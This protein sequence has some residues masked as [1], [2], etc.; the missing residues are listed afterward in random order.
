MKMQVCVFPKLEE[1]HLSK[2]NRLTDIWQ[3]EVSVDSFSNI[4]SVKIE[5]CYKLNKIFPS[6]MKGW[7]ECLDNLTVCSCESV[8]VIFEINDYEKID[9]FGGINTN[10]QVILLENLPKLKQLWSTDPGGIL[11][12]KKLR[13][14]DVCDCDE[15]INLFPASVAEDVPKLE[16]ISTLYCEKMVEIVTSQ[17]A[18]YANNDPL[19]FPELTCVRLEWLPN[20]KRFCKG[21]HLIKCPKLKQF[22]IHKRVKLNTF[23]KEIN[24]TTNKEEKCVF[25]AEEVTNITTF[26]DVRF[27]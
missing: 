24:E 18:S 1:I 25:S 7:V 9:E 4:I 15:L 26:F 14:M 12:F 6:H 27:L 10:L 2:M 16:R 19:V 8:E 3:T 17:D 21:K 23:L 11:N 13:A 20:I 5:E 22:S